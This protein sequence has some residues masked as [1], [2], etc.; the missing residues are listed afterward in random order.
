MAG[1]SSWKYTFHPFVDILG[2]RVAV[3][4][5]V[6]NFSHKHFTSLLGTEGMEVF[7][8]YSKVELECT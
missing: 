2:V 1:V 5:G 8:G 4:V 6:S 3:T 7:H